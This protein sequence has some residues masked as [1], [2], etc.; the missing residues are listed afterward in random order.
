MRIGN[1][2][3]FDGGVRDWAGCAGVEAGDRR[4]LRIALFNH[5][6]Y[7]LNALPC[8]QAVDN[9]LTRT[10]SISNLTSVSP[11]SM[12]K[13]KIAFNQARQAILTA[14]NQPISGPINIHVEY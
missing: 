14:L 12:H 8:A 11:T 4:V 13:G 1:R 7:I 6:R 10:V 9:Q 3:C 5:K 2:L